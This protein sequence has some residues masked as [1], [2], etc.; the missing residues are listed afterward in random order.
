[1]DDLRQG[2]TPTQHAVLDLIEAAAACWAESYDFE[3]QLAQA[4]KVARTAS[5][6]NTLS[7][8]RE[9]AIEAAARLI[10]AADQIGRL[11]QEHCDN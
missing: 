1:M 11:M 8:K 2:V 10:D 5:R 3:A 9:A 7:K 4:T 6:L